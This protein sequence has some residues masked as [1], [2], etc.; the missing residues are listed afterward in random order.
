MKIRCDWDV[1]AS[2]CDLAKLAGWK[3]DFREKLVEWGLDEYAED[4]SRREFDENFADEIAAIEAQLIP[5]DAERKQL[6]DDIRLWRLWCLQHGLD[7][8]PNSPRDVRFWI[9][10]DWAETKDA[11]RAL[12]RLRAL[13]FLA[14]EQ[15]CFFDPVYSELLRRIVKAPT[16][17]PLAN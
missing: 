14:H 6:Y 1:A 9:L 12:R 3:G 8:V 2:L 10:P 11:S 7:A 4:R 5:S 13:E 15:R 17:T 16:E